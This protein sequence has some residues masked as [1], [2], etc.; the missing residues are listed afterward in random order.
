L[1]VRQIARPVKNVALGE[2]GFKNGGDNA[3]LLGLRP[4]PSDFAIGDREEQIAAFP[5]R[6]AEFELAVPK[7]SARV[8]EM[9]IDC[10][11]YP[12]SLFDQERSALVQIAPS[13]KRTN[14]KW[15]G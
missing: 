10:E 3:S 4:T 12:I 6:R 11:V 8:S 7:V 5:Q 2:R 14:A 1:Q 9:T 15:L 13:G